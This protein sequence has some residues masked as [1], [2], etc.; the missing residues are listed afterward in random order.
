MHG[1]AIF[2]TEVAFNTLLVLVTKMFDT[3]I[4]VQRLHQKRAFE[5]RAMGLGA[6]G[7][8]LRVVVVPVVL[9]P[10]DEA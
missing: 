4:W 8:L 1:Y 3:R 9:S 6:C 2:A 7:Q 10:S 5:E